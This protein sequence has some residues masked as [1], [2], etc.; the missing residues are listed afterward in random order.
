MC[1]EVIRRPIG[2]KDGSQGYHVS[3]VRFLSPSNQVVVDIDQTDKSQN[4]WT[5]ENR[6]RAF[7]KIPR[8]DSRKLFIP[9]KLYQWIIDD[10][11]LYGVKRYVMSVCKY[12]KNNKLIRY[13]PKPQSIYLCIDVQ[14]SKIEDEYQPVWEVNL[15]APDG[16]FVKELISRP[17]HCSLHWRQLG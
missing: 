2:S 6:R 11:D 12:G 3:L 17:E 14:L 5:L 15:F 16:F 4:Y 1:L 8:N 7:L 13:W 9:G 10:V